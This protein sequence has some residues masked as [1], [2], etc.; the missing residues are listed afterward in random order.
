MGVKVIACVCVGMCMRMCAYIC[1]C[2][3][4]HIM[5]VCVCEHMGIVGYLSRFK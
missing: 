1:M 5:H 2:A 3:Y 4:V